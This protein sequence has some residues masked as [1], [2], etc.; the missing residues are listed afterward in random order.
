MAQPTVRDFMTPHPHQVESG[1]LLSRAHLL[2]RERQI[3]HLPV[4]EDENVVGVLSQRDVFLMETLKDA[5]PEAATA[6]EAMRAG[7]YVVAPDSPLV[8][9][10]LAMWR[11][12]LGCALVME[13]AQLVGIF[14][15]SDALRALAELLGERRDDRGLEAPP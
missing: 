14:T 2:M 12:K 4:F 10:V 6:G 13:G 11:D 5:E 1:E 7:P 9:V 3:R 15:R 8:E